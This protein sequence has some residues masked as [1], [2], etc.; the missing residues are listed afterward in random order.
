MSA[1]IHTNT[2]RFNTT[3][4]VVVAREVVL[5]NWCKGFQG[6]NARGGR[7]IRGR[8]QGAECAPCD[9]GSGNDTRPLSL[10]SARK[11]G[12]GRARGRTKRGAGRS[13]S[14]YI[15]RAWRQGQ[16]YRCARRQRLGRR[17]SGHPDCARFALCMGWAHAERHGAQ[18]VLSGTCDTPICHAP[19]CFACLFWPLPLQPVPDETPQAWMEVR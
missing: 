15:A 19:A 7:Q 13:R 14:A 6:M 9:T 8:G 11:R 10:R 12:A 5:N 16:A 1:H 3:K 18:R 17:V 4:T 2:T